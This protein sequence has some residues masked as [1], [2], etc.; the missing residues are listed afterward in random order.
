M[1]NIHCSS[2]DFTKFGYRGNVSVGRGMKFN[3]S[4]T[5]EAKNLTLNLSECQILVVPQLTKFA[6]NPAY[7]CQLLTFT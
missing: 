1:L 6:Y 2:N 7:I 5:K 3:E 4:F